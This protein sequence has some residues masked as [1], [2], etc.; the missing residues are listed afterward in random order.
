MNFVQRWWNDRQLRKYACEDAVDGGEYDPQGA[1]VAVHGACP[2]HDPLDVATQNVAVRVAQT[3][4]TV[5][6]QQEGLHHTEDAMT[7]HVSPQQLRAGL[8]VA[9]LAESGGLVLQ[10]RD[11]N[12]PSPERYLLAP[13]VAMFIFFLIGLIVQLGTKRDEEGKLHRAWWVPVVYGL[14]VLLIVSL[15]VTRMNAL[16]TSDAFTWTDAAGSIV[17]L[18]TVL[19]PSIVAEHLLTKLRAVA[20]LEKKRKLFAQRLQVE[21]E[22]HTI[23]TGSQERDSKERKEWR[24][25]AARS[26]RVYRRAY[27]NAGGTVPPVREQ[28]SLVP[29]PP[30]FAPNQVPVF[31]PFVYPTVAS[32]APSEVV[33]PIAIVPKP[34]GKLPEVTR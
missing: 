34:N 1:I 15:A 23:A 5:Q 32:N 14:A 25:V 22:A 30:S 20:P 24:Q 27:R 33:S 3:R 21:M 16:S 9:G 11:L 10:L 17:M 12:I 8:G 19:G 6:T 26:E 7:D 18:A 4:V 13:P 31:P 2:E 29:P 28:Q